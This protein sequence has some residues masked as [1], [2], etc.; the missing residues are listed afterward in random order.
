MPERVVL[1]QR[2]SLPALFPGNR[3]NVGTNK[4]KRLKTLIW[5][6]LGAIKSCGD[7]MGT[8]WEQSGN[9]VGTEWEQDMICFFRIMIYI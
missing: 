1:L 9:R 5:K 2:N 3:G 4:E 6:A 7:K 8:E